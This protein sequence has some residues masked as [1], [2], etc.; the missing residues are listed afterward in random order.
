V[1]Q[2]EYAVEQHRSIAQ[3]TLQ[4]QSM[5]TLPGLHHSHD[6]RDNIEGFLSMATE[7]DPGR[8]KELFR[9]PSDQTDRYPRIALHRKTVQF[10]TC[11]EST[12]EAPEGTIARLSARSFRIGAPR[13]ILENRPRYNN[14]PDSSVSKTSLCKLESALSQINTP[15]VPSY[16][17]VV[18]DTSPDTVEAAEAATPVEPADPEKSFV[19]RLYPQP[20]P[21][22][23]HDPRDQL[24]VKTLTGKTIM[25]NFKVTDTVYQL[26]MK[27]QDKEGI[28]PEFQRFIYGGKQL[29]DV[30][31]LYDYNTYVHGVHFGPHQESVTLTWCS[32]QRES[33]IHLVMRLRGA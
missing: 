8:V 4:W 3:L 29:E 20:T 13:Q 25:I 31:R 9:A 1:E 19:E 11:K 16:A 23:G 21:S 26:K 32:S 33:T 10:P 12:G 15:T 22:E 6:D 28:P 17:T 14:G 27:L 18:L 30:R 5:P 7:A 24:F 2:I